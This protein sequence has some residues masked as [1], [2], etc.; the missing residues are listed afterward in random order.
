[1]QH[2]QVRNFR[3]T[4]MIWAFEVETQD[5]GFARRFYQAA[6][7]RGVLLRPIGNTVYFMPPYVINEDGIAWLV[8]GTLGALQECLA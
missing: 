7:A 6:L 2:P 1:V 8:A 4:G 5:A 3:N